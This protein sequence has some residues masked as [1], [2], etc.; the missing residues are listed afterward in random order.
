MLKIG[1]SKGVVI[2]KKTIDY[3]G[4]EVDDIVKITIEKE[5][6]SEKTG[7]ENNNI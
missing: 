2:D 1:N 6:K 3:M 5:E 7:L 4:L